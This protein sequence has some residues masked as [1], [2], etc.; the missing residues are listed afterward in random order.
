MTSMSYYHMT[1][2]VHIGSQTLL[3]HRYL[4]IGI[5]PKNS[6]H[7]FPMSVTARMP[8]F[9][10]QNNTVRQPFREYLG[11][12]QL[13]CV[14]FKKSTICGHLYATFKTSEDENRYPSDIFYFI[15]YHKD[16]NIRQNKNVV[17]TPV[18]CHCYDGYL[19][20]E[21]HQYQISEIVAGTNLKFPNVLMMSEYQNTSSI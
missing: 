11:R 6:F 14:F 3:D 19:P 4:A 10:H 7:F 21:Y 12:W 1:C 5:T 16:T 15:G 9:G 17:A 13:N 18:V 8:V 20:S 2:G